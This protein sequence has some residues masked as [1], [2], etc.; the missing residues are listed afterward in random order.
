MKWISTRGYLPG[1]P[2]TSWRDNKNQYDSCTRTSNSCESAIKAIRSGIYWNFT[3]ACRREGMEKRLHKRSHRN[4][5]YLIGR[6]YLFRWHISINMLI[7]HSAIPICIVRLC[8]LGE[9]I[10]EQQLEGVIESDVM[11][12]EKA[13]AGMSWWGIFK[14]LLCWFGWNVV[15][16]GIESLRDDVAEQNSRYFEERWHKNVDQIILLSN[17]HS[18]VFKFHDV[19]LLHD[20]QTF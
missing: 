9:R 11:G 14:E 1:I 10:A 6:C 8:L 7:M 19:K 20:D 13:S 18:Q 2:R 17:Q 16:I 12:V 4:D 3:R 5:Q 15:D